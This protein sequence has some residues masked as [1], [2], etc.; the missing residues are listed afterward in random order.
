M[1]IEKNN[2]LYIIVIK[3]SIKTI[4]VYL[5]IKKIKILNIDHVVVKIIAIIAGKTQVEIFIIKWV[6]FQIIFIKIYKYEFLFLKK[7][8]YILCFVFFFFLKVYIHSN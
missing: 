6:K 3:F 8:M 1:I 7:N 2:I 5:N 4:L